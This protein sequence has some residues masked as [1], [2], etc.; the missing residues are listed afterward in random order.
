MVATITAMPSLTVGN[1]ANKLVAP[2]HLPY[3]PTVAIIASLSPYCTEALRI[4]VGPPQAVLSVVVVNPITRKKDAGTKTMQLCTGISNAQQQVKGTL[5]LLPGYGM[6]KAALLPYS[7]ALAAKGYRAVLVDLRAQGQSTGEYLGYGKQEARDLVQ[8]LGYLRQHGFLAGKV[9]L[10]GISYGAA[11]ALDTAAID[12][13]VSAV[14]AVAPFARVD[15]TIRRFLHMSDSSL[16][17]TIPPELLQQAIEQAGHLVGYPLAEADPLR[18]VPVIH[19][20]VLYLAGAED[21]V[22]PLR[23]VQALASKTPRSQMIIEPKK[24]HVTLTSDVPLIVKNAI[25]WFERYLAAS[26]GRASPLRN[27]RGTAPERRIDS[28]TICQRRRGLTSDRENGSNHA[29]ILTAYTRTA[30][31]WNRR[32]REELTEH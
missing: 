17:A 12:D 18:A 22:S 25:L 30:N 13:Q 16:A 19:A 29:V 8:V 6:P 1:L 21:P 27:Q 26:P 20:P 5:L 31:H 32:F 15:P 2:V 14:V 7:T 24:N 23:D 9:G 4:P 28:N 10:F 3:Q 11:V